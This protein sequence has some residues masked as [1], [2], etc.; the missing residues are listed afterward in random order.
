MT[1]VKGHFRDVQ[2]RPAYIKLHEQLWN[3]FVGNVL[4]MELDHVLSELDGEE[5]DDLSDERK[6][7]M[8]ETM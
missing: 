8:R 2:H 4:S 3:E 7:Q 5:F 1:F 6:Q